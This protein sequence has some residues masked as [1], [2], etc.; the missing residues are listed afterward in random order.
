MGKGK[1]TRWGRGSSEGYG[2]EIG[3][4]LRGQVRRLDGRWVA[5]M[6]A[7]D[8]QEWPTR[9][10]AMAKVESEIALQMK[11]ILEDWPIWQRELAARAGKKSASA[12]GMPAPTDSP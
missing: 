1:W 6:N 3:W 11:V 8:L 5:S 4:A 9:E 2:L 10:Q 12:R 7:T